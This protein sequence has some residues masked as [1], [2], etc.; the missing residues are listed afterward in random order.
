M[1]ASS[2]KVN[3][4]TETKSSDSEME[5]TPKNSKEWL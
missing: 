2:S 1:A 5:E 3:N 4:Y